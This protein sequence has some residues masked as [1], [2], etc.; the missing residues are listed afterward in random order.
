MLCY[1]RMSPD[2][3]R[4]VFGG[5]ARFTQVTPE[6]SVPALHRFMTRRFP[7]LAGVKVTH[8]WTGNTAFT[9]DALPHMGR[10]DGMHYLRAA[11]A[12]ALR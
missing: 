2:G 4:V 12:A 7:Q 5:R 11:T 10:Q 9:L 6:I 3:R 1:Y 8:A